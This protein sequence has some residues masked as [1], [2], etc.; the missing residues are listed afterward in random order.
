MDE[1]LHEWQEKLRDAFESGNVLAVRRAAGALM[2][3]REPLEPPREAPPPFTLGDE[4][5]HF[6]EGP[7]GERDEQAHRLLV[8]LASS[9]QASEAASTALFDGAFAAAEQAVKRGVQS[10]HHFVR[11]I[12]RS[13]EEESQDL[14]RKERRVFEARLARWLHEGLVRNT[15]KEDPRS[16][17]ASERWANS[18]QETEP[19]ASLA[20]ALELAELNGRVFGA[21]T[22]QAVRARLV[23]AQLALNGG[24]SAEALRQLEQAL[25]VAGD[26]C[27][28]LTALARRLQGCL[29]LELGQVEAGLRVLEALR[30]SRPKTALLKG[31]TQRLGTSA[32]DPL[33][34]AAQDLRANLGCGFILSADDFARHSTLAALVRL[35][36]ALERTGRHSQ[37]GAVRQT[38]ATWLT[39]AEQGAR[40][41]ELLE[42]LAKLLALNKEHGE[43]IQVWKRLVTRSLE[44]RGASHET[45]RRARR[46]LGEALETAGDFTGAAAA[47]G[48]LSDE[49][50]TAQAPDALEVR[51]QYASALLRAGQHDE[52]RSVWEDL[53]ARAAPGSEV[54]T[55]ARLGAASALRLSGAHEQ[56]LAGFERLFHELQRA[57]KLASGQGS[58]V[59]DELLQLLLPRKDPRARGIQQA[60]L[61]ATVEALV[62]LEQTNPPPALTQPG[63]DNPTVWKERHNLAVV[64]ARLGELGEAEALLREQLAR[65]EEAYG[66]QHPQVDHMRRSLHRVLHEAGKRPEAPAGAA[67]PSA[68]ELEAPL[69]PFPH[70][71]ENESPR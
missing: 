17:W 61:D 15:G 39:D 68:A 19:E 56:A 65:L 12:S 46:A 63:N 67:A 54:H 7:R 58:R 35:S 33:A 16:L 59:V 37:A 11:R 57:G 5:I 25:A 4:L 10:S 60:Y 42:S 51:S 52:A 18:L 43:A 23:C 32:E 70:F 47:L 53:V 34:Q 20:L 64:L 3:A 31:I 26:G 48:A 14:G 28:P 40:G 49:L 22:P 50:L 27:E 21:G 71:F 44:T 29:Q 6:D 55:R 9:P 2:N 62:R 36:L 13:F 24:Q 45:T 1:G 66:A 69:V 41:E 38:Y 8:Q 30:V